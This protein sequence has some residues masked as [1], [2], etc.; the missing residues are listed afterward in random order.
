[1]H[2]GPLEY[3]GYPISCLASGSIPTAFSAAAESL[4]QSWRKPSSVSRRRFNSANWSI[5]RLEFDRNVSRSLIFCFAVFP[6]ISASHEV[7]ADLL[8]ICFNHSAL[9]PSLLCVPA[10]GI[11]LR[12]VKLPIGVRPGLQIESI[13]FRSSSGDRCLARAHDR[14]QRQVQR[15]GRESS[16]SS[17]SHYLGT[18]H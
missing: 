11:A 2:S 1:M 13:F 9:A 7:P 10:I 4:S 14:L 12:Q 17:G 16:Q 5:A 6:V 18:D 3:G 15:R 8:T